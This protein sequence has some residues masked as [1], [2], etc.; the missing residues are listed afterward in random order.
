MDIEYLLLLQNF[1]QATGDLL[2]PL[3][4]LISELAA[5]PVLIGLVSFVYWAVDKSMGS[6]LM[7]NYTGSTLL[8]QTVKLAACVYR[9]W[10]RDSRIAPVPAALK[11][12]TGYSFPSGHTQ[13][14]TAAFGSAA[15]W[16]WNRRRWVSFLM[17]AMVLLTGFSRNYLGVHTP[18]DVLVGCGLCCIYLILNARL[19]AWV[20]SRPSR[21]WIVAAVGCGLAALCLVYIQCKSYPLDYVD[22]RLLVDPELMKEDAFSAAGMVLGF[23]PGWLAERRFIRFTTERHSAL[24]FA[25]AGAG[26]VPM[27]VIYKLLP[28]LLAPALGVCWAELVSCAVLAFYVMAGLPSLIRLVQSRPAHR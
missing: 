16:F 13:S 18:Q 19:M 14:A 10:V 15:I 5:G 17:I 9:P 24:Q 11:G 20:E 26:L 25:L 8:N 22:G 7:L 3:M 12:A 27:L 23:Y 6:F 4:L 21:D 1:R 28:A 2:T